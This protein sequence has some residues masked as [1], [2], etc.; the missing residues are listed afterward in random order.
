MFEKAE[1][2]WK[3]KHYRLK[4]LKKVNILIVEQFL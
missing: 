4:E 3:L 1:K 2:A